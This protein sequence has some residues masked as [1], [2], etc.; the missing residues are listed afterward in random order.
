[1]SERKMLFRE[2]LRRGAV[3]FPWGA[4]AVYLIFLVGGMFVLSCPTGTA[5]PVV[6][7]ALAER[8]GNPVTA[9]LVQFVWSGL[10]GAVLATAGIPF[11]LEGRTALASAL[12][13]LVTGAVFTL[14]GWRCCWFAYWQTWLC[15]MGLLLLCYVL[16]WAVRYVGWRQDVAALRRGLGLP[17]TAPGWRKTLPWFFLAAAVELALPWLLRAVDARDVPVLTGLFYPY[18]ILPLFCLV[19]GCSLGR[20]HRGTWLAYPVFCA[21][22]TL[23]CVFTLYNESALF[24]AAVAATAALAGGALGAARRRWQGKKSE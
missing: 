4:A 19:S 21:V 12:H 23:P 14:A 24:Q 5:V 13:F 7:A 8:W 10:L 22:L 6:T 17:E 16:L 2:L 3:G 18:L 20:R 9:A 15:L 1:M 11:Q